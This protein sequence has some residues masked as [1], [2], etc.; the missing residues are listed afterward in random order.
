MDRGNFD[1]DE[2]GG[3]FSFTGPGD[4]DWEPADVQQFDGEFGKDKHS[5]DSSNTPTMIYRISQKTSQSSQ[6]RNT[7]KSYHTQKM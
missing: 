5:L 3:D 2:F 7:T 6:T 1:F 4:W